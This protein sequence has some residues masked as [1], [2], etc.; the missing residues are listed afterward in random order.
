MKYLFQ[1]D[2]NSDQNFFFLKKW[3]YFFEKNQLFIP[4]KKSELFIRKNH[5]YFFE[6]III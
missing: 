1:N 5:D 2:Q 4:K 3:N 6:K